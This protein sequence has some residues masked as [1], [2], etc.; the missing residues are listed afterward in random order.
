MLSLD[1]IAWSLPDGDPIL[2]DISLNIAP[3]KLTVVTGPNGGGKTSLAKLIAGLEMPEKAV[4]VC[5]ARISPDWTLPSAPKKAS[6]TPFSS[7]FAL[8]D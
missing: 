8:R 5:W 1:H 6:P 7:R 4:S 3:G 2:K